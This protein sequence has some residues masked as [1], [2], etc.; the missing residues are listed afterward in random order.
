MRGASERNA[1]PVEAQS[2]NPAERHTRVGQD[3]DDRHR[4]GRELS[5]DALFANRPIPPE[6]CSVDKSA[7]AEPSAL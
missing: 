7:G 6:C 5:H 1:G 2:R 4:G 3:E